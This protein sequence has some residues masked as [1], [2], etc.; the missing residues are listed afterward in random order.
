MQ[1]HRIELPTPFPVGPVNAYLLA[2]TPLT[3]ID[4][5]PKTETAQ[6]ALE[7]GVRGAGSRIEDIR[8]VV[9][10]HGH[11]DHFGNAPWVAS[12]SGAQ[13]FAHPSDRPKFAGERWVIDHLR[14]HFLAAGLPESFLRTFTERMR[15]MRQFFDAVTEFQPLGDGDTLDAD[16]GRLRVLHCPGHSLGHICLY[17]DDGALIAGDL[18]LEEISPN[19]IVEFDERGMRIPTLP[20]YL[21]S[22]RRILLLNCD[23]AYPGHGGPIVNPNARIRE[24]IAHHEQRK[25]AIHARL[26][27]RGKTL[28]QLCQE[29]YQNL[30]ELN[31]MLALSEVIGHLD[32]LL[33]EKRAAMSRRSGIFFFRVK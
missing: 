28:V 27:S 9:L 29:L 1:V 16:G 3:L 13:I 25:E 6:A 33:E 12:R 31:L 8:R 5:G 14:T 23:L 32:L 26:D 20:Q 21:H 24:L 7:A 17:H 15:A 4:A 22:L 18:L 2:G 11:S 19:P 30:D 10:T